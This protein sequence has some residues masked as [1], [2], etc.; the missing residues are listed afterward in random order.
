MHHPAV[1][2][3]GGPGAPPAICDGGL[4]QWNQ[5]GALHGARAGGARRQAGHTPELVS[6]HRHRPEDFLVVF[7]SA[8]LRNRVASC[9]SVE[10]QGDKL[11]FRPWNCQSQA[12]HAM[13]G[14]KVWLDIEGI[15]LMPGIVRWLRICWTRPARWTRWRRKPV[16]VPTCP[17][18]SSPPGQPI[19]RTYPQCSGSPCRSVGEDAAC[20]TNSR[21]IL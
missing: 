8:E 20:V 19:R 3:G 21:V 13:L 1:V 5:K 16:P 2:D 10:Y 17:P 18:S 15:P 12:V 9:P 6:V 4:C 7:A 14:F 11:I